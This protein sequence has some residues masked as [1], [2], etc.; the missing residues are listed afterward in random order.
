MRKSKKNQTLWIVVVLVAVVSALTT[1]ALLMLRAK[2]HKKRLRKGEKEANCTCM[3]FDCEAMD[4][5]ADIA[6]VVVDDASSEEP[7]E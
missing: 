4:D 6:D 3:S 2:C 1:V 7:Q 5:A